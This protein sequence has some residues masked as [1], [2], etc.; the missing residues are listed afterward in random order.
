MSGNS[1]AH[2][3]H[4]VCMKFTQ[5]ALP[6]IVERSIVPPPSCGTTRAGAAWPTWKPA[7]AAS[8]PAGDAPEPAGPAAVGDADDPEGAPAAADGD[9]PGADGDAEIATVGDGV[10]LSPTGSGPTKTNAARTPPATRTPASR[11]ARIAAP[12]FIRAEGTSTSG[13]GRRRRAAARMPI[14]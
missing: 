7:W 14:P 9:P 11:P 12:V 2:S 13:P 4:V 3:G 5:T 10:G 8:V 6:R 1:S